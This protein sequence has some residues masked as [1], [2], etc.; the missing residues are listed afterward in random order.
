MR[1]NDAVIDAET[2]K[3]TKLPVGINQRIS[4]RLLEELY[5]PRLFAYWEHEVEG[6]IVGI[7]A[8]V[9]AKEIGHERYRWPADWWQALKDRWAPRWFLKRWPVEY[10]T[11]HM[12]VWHTYPKLRIHGEEPLLKVTF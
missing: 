7:R 6:M 1:Y 11:I 8:H 3:L 5:E 10:H 4:R 9:L 12:N 2:I